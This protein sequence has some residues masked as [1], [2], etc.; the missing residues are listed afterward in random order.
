[1]SYCEMI[2]IAVSDARGAS[3]VRTRGAGAARDGDEDFGAHDF[4]LTGGTALLHDDVARVAIDLLR[5][6]DA[7]LAGAVVRAAR[8][9]GDNGDLV[10]GGERRLV[11]VER[12]DLL[13]VPVAVAVD[14]DLVL[15]VVDEIVDAGELLVEVIEQLGDVGGVDLDFAAVAGHAAEGRWDVDSD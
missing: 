8:D 11:A 10:A 9:R 3:C 1:M 13:V 6:E 5:R 15:A 7:R 2:S 12:A 14:G 4:A